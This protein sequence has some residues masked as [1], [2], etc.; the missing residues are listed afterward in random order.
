MSTLLAV[1]ATTTV[2]ATLAVATAFVALGITVLSV[3]L[4]NLAP[5]A[6][7]FASLLGFATLVS[8]VAIQRS[9]PRPQHSCR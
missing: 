3:L 4:A 2:R 6:A 5:V 9:G 7:L 1:A 8:A